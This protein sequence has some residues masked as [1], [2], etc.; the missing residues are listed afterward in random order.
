MGSIPDETDCIW[1]NIN[2][3]F[4]A[5]W[6]EF[7]PGPWWGTVPCRQGTYMGYK[8]ENKPRRCTITFE[9]WG[10]AIS[11]DKWSDYWDQWYNI[12]RGQSYY[13]AV[14]VPGYCPNI[15]NNEDDGYYGGG[16]SWWK[17]SKSGGQGSAVAQAAELAVPNDGN[18]RFELSGNLVGAS[19]RIAR[20]QK[21]YVCYVK[22]KIGT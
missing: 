3:V 13:P 20:K 7:A 14:P 5:P 16:A 22:R 9:V 15:Y 2:G 4:K 8:Y 21:D 18:T 19:L 17:G 6:Y 1:V 11:A 10:V 12:F